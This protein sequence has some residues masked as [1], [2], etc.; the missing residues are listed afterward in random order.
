MNEMQVDFLIL[1]TLKIKV[2]LSAKAGLFRNSGELHLWD[3]QAN[4]EPQACGENKGEEHLY[5]KGAEL[6][7]LFLSTTIIG[8][9]WKSHVW[10]LL[11]G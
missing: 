2:F 6:E 8:L 4:T 1:L 3:T 11:I 5:K 7:G 10:G 9:N